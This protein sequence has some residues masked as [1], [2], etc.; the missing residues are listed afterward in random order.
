MSAYAWKMHSWGS[1]SMVSATACHSEDECGWMFFTLQT[2]CKV[3]FCVSGILACGGLQLKLN[4]YTYTTQTS[5]HSEGHKINSQ[6]WMYFG[7]KGLTD[8]KK[9]IGEGVEGVRS[10]SMFCQH[11]QILHH[12]GLKDFH[13]RKRFL[14]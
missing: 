5:H 4:V 3:L 9:G 13:A 2:L 1:A 6:E 11:H 8:N 12:Y 14:I 7:L 10:C